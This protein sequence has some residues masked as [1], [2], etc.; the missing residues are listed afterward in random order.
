MDEYYQRSTIAGMYDLRRLQIKCFASS[1]DRL[2]PH[3]TVAHQSE[4]LS[5]IISLLPRH[6]G[7]KAKICQPTFSVDPVC[8]PDC[9]AVTNIRK[10]YREAIA[11]PVGVTTKPHSIYLECGFAFLAYHHRITKTR[12]STSVSVSVG[13]CFP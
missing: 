7:S 2:A 13:A 9:Y 8:P 11:N 5:L 10:R 3:L 12:L 1:L 6:Q 4:K